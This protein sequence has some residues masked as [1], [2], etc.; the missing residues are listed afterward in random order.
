MKAADLIM[1][2]HAKEQ[3]VEHQKCRVKMTQHT[4]VRTELC[5]MAVVEPQMNAVRVA[6][7]DLLSQ[8]QRLD[9]PSL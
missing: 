8:S 2:K 5:A 3:N 7:A 6:A 9:P 1:H 4:Q